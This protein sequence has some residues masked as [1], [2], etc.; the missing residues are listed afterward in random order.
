MAR[1][2]T[3]L[4][5]SVTIAMFA[6]GCAAGPKYH[7]PAVQVPPSYKEATPPTPP[8]PAVPQSSTA[9]QSNAATQTPAQPA[10]TPINPPFRVAQ[11][12]DNALRGDWWELFNDPELNA[13][14]AQGPLISR[15]A[16]LSAK[17]AQTIGP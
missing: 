3:V 15:P 16:R 5:A 9:P 1:R 11:P 6:A 10:P 8:P 4:G 7:T 14:D 13:L 12:N 17:H 2:L